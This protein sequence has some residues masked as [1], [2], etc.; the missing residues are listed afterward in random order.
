MRV[1]SKPFL[2]SFYKAFSKVSSVAIALFA[3]STLVGWAFD[4]Q[5]LK[6]I[7]PHW[8]SIKPNTGLAFLLLGCSLLISHKRSPKSHSTSA[9]IVTRILAGTAT[10][11][12]FLTLIEYLC[13]ISIGIDQMLFKEPAGTVGTIYPGRM[14]PNS[15]LNFVLIGLALLFIDDG[16]RLR[17][18][19]AQMLSIT[20]GLIGLLGIVGYAY[21]VQMLYGLSN[22][23]DMA[24]HTAVAFVVLSSAV[25]CARPERGLM[26]LLSGDSPGGVIVR[27]LLAPALL[28]ILLLGW[29]VLTGHNAGLYS[30]EQGM[31][32]FAVLGVIV[33]AG[34]VLKVSTSLQEEHLQRK[35]LEVEREDYLHR[36]KIQTQETDTRNQQLQGLFDSAP[37]GMALFDAEAPYKVLAHNKVYQEFWAEPFRSEGMVGKC[38]IDYVP[39]AEESG[40]FEVFRHVAE[41]KQAQTI[42]E[43]PYDGMERGRT[44]WNWNLSPVV[45]NGKVAAFA[46]MLI[47]VT[48]HVVSRDK[49][50][51]MLSAEQDKNEELATQGEELSAMNEELAS[52]SEELAS[53][54]QEL[55][56]INED[57][58]DLNQK[59]QQANDTLQLVSDTASHFLSGATLEH[60]LETMLATAKR[61]VGSDAAAVAVFDNPDLIRIWV[62]DLGG[63]NC[64]VAIP[65]IP[66]Y[67]MPGIAS[68]YTDGVM[69]DNDPRNVALPLGHIP[70]NNILAIRVEIRN[71]WALLLLANKDGGFVEE[72][73]SKVATLG[74]LTS[75]IVERAT[76]DEGER[77]AKTAAEQRAAEMESFLASMAD[78]VAQLDAEGNCIYMNDAG[79]EIL[80]IPLSE[81]PGAFFDY[82]RYSL[83][84]S[85][86]SIEQIAAWRALHGE[87]VRNIYYK[88]VGP[89]GKEVVVDTSASPIRDGE[90][91]I[92]GA[93]N[94]FRDV[95]ERID[96]ERRREELYTREHR[97]AELLQQALIP[98]QVTYELRKCRA[99]VKYQPALREAEVGG[100]F[101]DVFEVGENK[102]GI[103]IGDVAGK[104]LKAA[105][106]VAAARYAI[107]SYAFLDPNPAR[108]MTL[109][110]DALSREDTDSLGMLTAFYA[111]VDLDKQTITYANAGH[112]PP[113]IRNREGNIKELY[114]EGRAL[115]LM[116]GFEYTEMTHVLTLGDQLIMFTDGITEA[117]A[118]GIVLFEQQGIVEYLDLFSDA[119]VE[120]IA[121][122]LLDAATRHAGG[123]LQDDAAIVVFELVSDPCNK[124]HTIIG[125]SDCAR[126]LPVCRQV[127][128]LAAANAGFNKEEQWSITSAVFEACVNAL[129]HGTGD[130][131]NR[132]TLT[133]SVDDE[134]M[135]F[136]IADSGQGYACP[137]SNPIP[138]ASS[139]RG[140]GIPLM[141]AFMDDVRFESDGGCKV[142]LV[143]RLPASI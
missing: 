13:G 21:G 97:I 101:Y 93:T 137:I 70:L 66:G 48:G 45:R 120:M 141:T 35:Q 44:W 143:K 31:A 84:G 116:G 36:L 88:V 23:T 65:V 112:E 72:D 115:G 74:R 130:K 26:S 133:I 9:L 24:F 64:H 34:L 1:V 138:P 132:A 59:I 80:G 37:A 55:L 131:E 107:R 2:I 32:I 14:S 41:T 81:P 54:N 61:L 75:I 68:K 10:L 134:A 83:D 16:R 15:A 129:T 136:V 57:L 4:I 3:L 124:R 7:S 38:V 102:V 114:L 86:I 63:E 98:P 113:L 67:R 62:Y 39:D 78:G 128:L 140:R 30:S 108:V 82:K 33:L 19:T 52:Q 77:E 139:H 69:I 119:P 103:L 125:F 135:E 56:Q 18:Q 99:A 100:D 111:L 91:R 87:T 50:Q 95:T 123:S 79:K 22:Y 8:V 5:T 127:T 46:H 28:L 58:V 122:G 89:G 73:A 142:T 76:L 25:I 49:I 6:S 106:R 117:R 20:A 51:E 90:G 53:T 110:N 60:S 29:I 105:M 121:S 42:Y 126:D 92:I 94:V 43:F 96:F 27:W 109:A 118:P 71:G 85:M 47:E 12:G 17:Y 40:V 11:I 104:G